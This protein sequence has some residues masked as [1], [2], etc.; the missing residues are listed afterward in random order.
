MSSSTM[1]LYESP[2]SPNSPRVRIY[3]AEK[4]LS[5]P[6]VAIDLGTKQQFSEVYRAINLRLVVPTR[7]HPCR[8]D[9]VLRC[10]GRNSGHPGW[11]PER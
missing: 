8:S 10:T 11:F 7:S 4:G 1:K 2:S 3:L 9:A 6:R 5:V